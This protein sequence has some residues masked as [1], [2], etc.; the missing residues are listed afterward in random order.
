[1]AD[2]LSELSRVLVGPEPPP[3]TDDGTDAGT[4]GIERGQPMN[5]RRQH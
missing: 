4:G 5:Q 3:D 1:M 2:E